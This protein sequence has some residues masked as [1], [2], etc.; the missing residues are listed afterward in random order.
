MESDHPSTSLE[1]SVREVKPVTFK[2]AKSALQPVTETPSETPP[3]TVKV[4]LYQDG[5]KLPIVIAEI[6]TF[7]IGF[8]PL[9]EKS[10]GVN[11]MVTPSASF[12]EAQNCSVSVFRA[13]DI[14]GKIKHSSAKE[15]F[16]IF[17]LVNLN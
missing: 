4:A 2:P 17:K 8:I 12:P 9:T 10:S 15:I 11:E 13:K 1:I 3:T 5:Q 6:E 7:V 14:T 16:F